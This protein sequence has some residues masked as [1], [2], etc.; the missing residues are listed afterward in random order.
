MKK[1]N[2]DNIQNFILFISAIALM[3]SMV[4]ILNGDTT[5]QSDKNNIIYLSLA[6]ALVVLTIS[7]CVMLMI[8]R[9][10]TKKYIYLSYS[11]EDKEIVEKIS[12]VLSSQLKKL[13]TYRFEIITIDSIPFGYDINATMQRNIS[14]SFTAII[15]VS[16]SYLE[17]SWCLQEFNALSKA[18]KRIIPIV[19]DSYNDLKKLPQNISNIKAL[20]LSECETGAEFYAAMVVS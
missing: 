14:K 17:N 9:T 20:S 18:Q 2:G 16:S 1:F 11:M 19:T 10:R 8:K 5:V 13:S 4:E 15:I 7:G 3:S 12:D 6:L